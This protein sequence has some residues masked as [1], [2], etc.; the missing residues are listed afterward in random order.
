MPGCSDT[1]AWYNDLL[2]LAYQSS[3]QTISTQFSYDNNIL[4][5]E[6][7]ETVIIISYRL[8]IFKAYPINK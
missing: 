4:L 2:L 1:Q 8:I 5:D 6:M 3:C 7:V